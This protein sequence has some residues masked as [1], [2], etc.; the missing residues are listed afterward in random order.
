MVAHTLICSRIRSLYELQ[1]YRFSTISNKLGNMRI[2]GLEPRALRTVIN[3]PAFLS[4]RSSG[5]AVCRGISDRVT[6]LEVEN[7]GRL[8]IVSR[9]R[10][11]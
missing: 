4:L 1:I 11:P 6:K 2:S 7:I 8:K 9:R 3:M 5:K 10:N